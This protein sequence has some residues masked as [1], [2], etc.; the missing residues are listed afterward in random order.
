LTQVTVLH[1][2]MVYPPTD[3]RSPIQ[4]LTQQC[5][6]GSQTRN[7]LITTHESDALTTAPAT[8]QATL[9]VNRLRKLLGSFQSTDC[10]IMKIGLWRR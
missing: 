3:G 2:E 8:K 10:R 9:G 5:T 6:A 4:V 1:T 7:L